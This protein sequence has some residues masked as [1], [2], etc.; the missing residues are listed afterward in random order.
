MTR[1]LSDSPPL[2]LS[3]QT[4]QKKKKK[5]P[6]NTH[7]RQ[8]KPEKGHTSMGSMMPWGKPGADPTI[9][10]VRQSR[11]VELVNINL[12]WESCLDTQERPK[13]SFFSEGLE[14]KCLFSL[15]KS[16]RSKDIWSMRGINT[17]EYIPK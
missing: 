15:T 2:Y 9:C 12:S 14:Q 4:T 10:N 3:P 7:Q 11:M 13:F 5:R 6:K 8:K 1:A 16:Q 17:L